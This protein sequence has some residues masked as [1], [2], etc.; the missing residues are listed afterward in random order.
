[1]FLKELSFK[2][3]RQSTRDSKKT[4]NRT[5]NALRSLFHYL[6]VTADL[7]DGE[8][9]FYRNVMLKIHLEKG[10]KEPI[11]YRNAKFFP[12][13]YTDEK[14]HKWL[15]YL[16]NQYESTLGNRAKSS[17]IFNKERDLAIIALL[18]ALGYMYLN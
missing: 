6:T 1:M 5:I 13:L 3:N 7:K 2:E 16:S 12:M 15:D 10:I 9:Y 8:P 14:K 17:F 18:L 11:S 4:I